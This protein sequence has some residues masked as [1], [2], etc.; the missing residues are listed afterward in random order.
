MRAKFNILI[1]PYVLK[2]EPLFCI[3]KRKDTKIWQFVAG[4]GEDEES[5]VVAAMRELQEE[6]GIANVDAE[7]LEQLD[8][9]GTVP[10]Y[11]FKELKESWKEGLYVVPIT[12]FAYPYTDEIQLSEEHIAYKWVTYEQ[13]INLLHYD[14]DK[15]T[16]WELRMRI[17]KKM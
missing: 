13:A 9:H 14:L 1:I 11:F 17:V 10:S 3:L 16:L 12:T 7:L 8:S 4:G 6:I 5:R 2:E 15:T